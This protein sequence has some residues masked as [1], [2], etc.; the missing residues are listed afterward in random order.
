MRALGLGGRLGLGNSCLTCVCQF[1]QLAFLV[2]GV[3]GLAYRIPG[4]F[5]TTRLPL[6]I[7]LSRLALSNNHDHRNYTNYRGN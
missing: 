4:R 7:S 3:S 5:G 1:F 6:Q 2:K